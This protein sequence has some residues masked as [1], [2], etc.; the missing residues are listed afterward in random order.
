MGYFGINDKDCFVRTSIDYALT[1][2]LHL[3]FGVDIFAG[4]QGL[5]GQYKDNDE[6]WIKVKYSF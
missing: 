4:E 6:V 5:L 2:E 1:D 3:L